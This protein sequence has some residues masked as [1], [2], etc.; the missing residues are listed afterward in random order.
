VSTLRLQG[1]RANAGQEAV[2]AMLAQLGAARFELRD[3]VPNL[4]IIE[5][6]TVF[7]LL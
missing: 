7:P 1:H 6:G 3:I 2:L 5:L 4:Q